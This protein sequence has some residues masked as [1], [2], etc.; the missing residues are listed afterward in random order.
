VEEK[1]RRGDA[2][3]KLPSLEK[4]GYGFSRGVVRSEKKLFI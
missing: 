1:R 4:E 3:I 2:E